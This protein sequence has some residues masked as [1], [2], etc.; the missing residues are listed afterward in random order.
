MKAT[1][2]AL[3]VAAC[4]AAVALWATAWLSHQRPTAATPAAYLADQAISIHDVDEA[5][6]SFNPAEHA[7]AAQALYD[8]RRAALD[9]LLSGM[10][11]DQAAATQGLAVDE[12]MQ[13][14]ITRRAQSTS[15]SEARRAFV[16]D[17]TAAAAVR[18]LLEPPRFDIAVEARDPALGPPS[19]PVTIVEFSD[20]QCPYC[21]QVA[22][23][24][25]RVQ[26]A[27][28]D[29]VRVVWKDLPIEQIHPWAFMAAEAAHCAGA[30]DQFWSYH[31]AVFARQPTLDA[32]TFG[33]LAAGAGL[34]VPLFHRCLQTQAS[35]QGVRASVDLARR[36]GVNATPTIFVNGR[37]VSGAQSF[38][39][40][41]RIVDEELAGPRAIK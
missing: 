41:A 13:R 39:A 30:Q 11:I 6:R 33:A 4:G 25:K 40:I 27:Y 3:L 21:A 32:E 17:L 20:F 8:G 31:D 9:R 26:M 7:Q 37:M 38:E 14:E 2:R 35:A 24:L 19:A 23:T 12:Y 22:P 5:W 15:A 18:V 16:A 10:L 34:D 28:G 36:L 1:A 29:R